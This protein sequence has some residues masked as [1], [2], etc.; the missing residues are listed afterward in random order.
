MSG[1]I[2]KDPVFAELFDVIRGDL[3]DIVK[4]EVEN[5]RRVFGCINARVWENE[6]Y[7]EFHVEGGVVAGLPSIHIFYEHKLL[8]N[9]VKLYVDVQRENMV[10]NI[11]RIH[12]WFL[13]KDPP[14]CYISYD[15]LT[16]QIVDLTHA[17]IYDMKH[18]IQKEVED[19][20]SLRG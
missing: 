6:D 18:E 20:E 7:L 13:R 1:D 16:Q 5:I 8:V 14:A 4:Q 11:A 2:L 10:Y 9:E 15:I 19:V 17:I 3:E 12:M